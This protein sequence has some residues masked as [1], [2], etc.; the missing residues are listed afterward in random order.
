MKKKLD[1]ATE[2]EAIAKICARWKYTRA[3]N[4]ADALQSTLIRDTRTNLNKVS[5]SIMGKKLVAVSTRK[6]L[7]AL[8][9]L[10]EEYGW[11][12]KEEL[13]RSNKKVKNVN[14]AGFS[15]SSDSRPSSPSQP[16]GLWSR[17]MSFKDKVVGEIPGAYTQAFNFEDLMEDDEESDDEVES[18][19]EGLVAIKLPKELKQKIRYPWARALI[20]KVYGRSVG[21]NFLQTR[22]LALWKPAGRLDCVDLG[23]GFFLTRLSLKEDYEAVL[24][25]GPWFIGEHFLSIRPWV[26]DF[27]PEL[28]NVSSIAVWIRLNGLP[29]EYYNAEA[30][31]LIGKAIGN[32]LRVDTHTASE[33]RGR[34][35]R[36]CIQI[37][38]TKP[39]VT[40]IKIGKLEQSVCYEGIQKL[41]FDCGRMG[42]I[43]ENCP[44]TIRQEV[45]PQETVGVESEKN[46]VRSCNLREATADKAGEGP[47]EIV[48]DNVQGNVE[49]HVPDSTYGPWIVVKRKMNGTKSQKKSTG[50]QSRRNAGSAQWAREGSTS[51]DPVGPLRETKRKIS[52]SKVMIEAQGAYSATELEGLKALKGLSF[53]SLSPKLIENG[54]KDSKTEKAKLVTESNPPASVKGKKALVRSR[55]TTNV[56]NSSVSPSEPQAVN[57]PLLFTAAPICANPNGRSDQGTSSKVQTTANAKSKVSDEV[58]EV[59]AGRK[60]CYSDMGLGLVHSTEEECMEDDSSVVRNRCTEGRLRSDGV[61]VEG[62]GQSVVGM[63]TGGA[64]IECSSEESFEAARMDVEGS[65]K[66]A[67]LC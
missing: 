9:L 19:R 56:F 7:K 21:F 24:Q 29:I 17:A 14:H 61:C 31:F 5:R 50:P 55:A 64:G 65:G 20:V 49:E 27:K 57:Q 32:V 18:L 52:P 54:K 37:D 30:L 25:K 47:S 10:R 45:P 40:A 33:T 23:Y 63:S 3:L 58:S 41:C 60:L 62:S 44:Y 26:P 16:Q 42:H 43:R 39:L 51:G 11:T 4:V 12:G 8:V 28:A 22:L 66:A 46:S 53:T 36:L 67:T 1:T 48:P 15:D 6:E 59:C 13:A 2:M 35:A 34:F 38:V